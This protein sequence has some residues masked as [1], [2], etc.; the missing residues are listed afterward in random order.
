MPNVRFRLKACVR[1]GWNSGLCTGAPSMRLL[2]AL[3]WSLA[4]CGEALSQP[5]PLRDP[6]FDQPLDAGSAAWRGNAT[7]QLWLDRENP[8]SGEAS[9]RVSV[10]PNG[11]QGFASVSQT[12]PAGPF[13]G[14]V[15]R[16]RA[17]ARVLPGSEGVGLWLRVDRPEGGA[18]FFDNMRDR[19]IRD[20]SWRY[21]DILAPVA[22]G[23]E[24]ILVG[25]LAQ[26]GTAWIDT[27]SIED[28]GPI[29]AGD[30]GPAPLT[31]R[32]VENLEAFALL[33]GYVRW[34]HPTAEGVDW[35]GVALAGVDR[36]EGAADPADLAAR[37]TDFFAPLAP[38]LQVSSEGVPR[39]P[40]M[41]ADQ[42]LIRWSHRGVEMRSGPLYRSELMRAD[43]YEDITGDLPGGVSFRLPLTV[44]QPRGGW[45]LAHF[46]LSRPG[47]YRPSG[48]DRTTRLAAVI[49][50]WSVLQNFYPYFD[51]VGDHWRE[52]LPSALAGAAAG[53]SGTELLS[54]L[55]RLT[56]PLVDGHALIGPQDRAG[57]LPF[58]W[59][60]IE[61]RLVITQDVEGLGVSAGDV[62]VAIDGEATETAV[63]AE[64]ALI[65]GSPQWRLHRA[66]E[67]LRTGPVGSTVTLEV[68]S[69][70]TGSRSITVPLTTRGPADNLR[71]PRPPVV[72]DL[73][74]GVIYIDL[75]RVSENDL[76]NA[77]LTGVRAA[78]FDLRGYPGRV[79]ASWLAQLVDQDISTAPL[80]IEIATRPDRAEEG[81]S[82]ENLAWWIRPAQPYF[83]GPSVFLTDARA[84]SYA[85][86][87][88][89]MVEA[90]DVGKIIGSSTAGA[91]GDV[92]TV[93]LPGGYSLRWT[94]LEVPRHDGRPLQGIGIPPDV[95]V[96]RT[97]D[98][99][100][101]HRDEVL[102]AALGVL[103][104]ALEENAGDPAA[105]GGR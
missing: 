78:V 43:A 11:S 17:A 47:S 93:L 65:S 100:R 3:I 4:L 96:R 1:A 9:L 72:S 45:H 85:E 42:S 54:T 20:S 63:A 88:L 38:T 10:V 62:V 52:A 12:I 73:G 5:G 53:P 34:F 40:E 101:R 16:F 81:R 59:D 80:L 92:N 2:L 8:E 86:T 18:S 7:T 29:G 89:G 23:S 90:Y 60:W 48:D 58:Q 19:P 64:A 28:L 75:T 46:D 56:V 105:V 77:D 31:S 41:R 50:A 35:N 91:N 99:V 68:A 36:I 66:L 51:I 83:S 39:V 30:V 103:T 25:L 95:A 33:Y 13:E 61:E 87:L 14:R 70:G 32:G 37:L 15:I 26:S 27:A 71:E 82:T 21:Y 24:R 55:E 94:G 97:I 76:A 57:G 79:R 44:P 104:Q 69:V 67:R 22:V 49:V 102:H 84:I 98:G 74:N 6:G